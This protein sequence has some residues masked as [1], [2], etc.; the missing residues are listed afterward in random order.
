M[1][2]SWLS[3]DITYTQSFSCNLR[4]KQ[5]IIFGPKKPLFGFIFNTSHLSERDSIM[6][7]VL[8]CHAAN[9]GSN[10]ARGDDFFN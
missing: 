5:I 10:P 7:S 2:P 6:V 3:S 1:K 9:P 4:L 8:A